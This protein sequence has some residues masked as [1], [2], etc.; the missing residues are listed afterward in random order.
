MKKIIYIFSV[1]VFSMLSTNTTF[2][3]NYYTDNGA[4]YS[5]EQFQRDV[6]SYLD[7]QMT[8][9]ENQDLINNINQAYSGVKTQFEIDQM[10]KKLDEAKKNYDDTSAQIKQVQDLIYQQNLIIA[11][12]K[13]LKEAEQKEYDYKNAVCK[14][15]EAKYNGVVEIQSLADNCAK[16]DVYLR[17]KTAVT[18]PKPVKESITTYKPSV[19]R[20]VF[21]DEETETKI[22]NILDEKPATTSST[23][24]M[25]AESVVQKSFL[26]KTFE[27]IRS[28]L[29]WW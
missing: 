21:L 27:K 13:K 25:H 26:K 16:Y 18:T 7:S 10:Q 29:V 3:Y 14:E 9:Q 24:T 23:T 12:Q 28:F 6:K 19:K 5:N 15:V 2:A 1:L 8:R 22:P 17:V 11:E 4:T 20:P